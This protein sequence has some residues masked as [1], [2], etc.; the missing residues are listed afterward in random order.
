[1]YQFDKIQQ[2]LMPV[3]EIYQN[4]LSIITKGKANKCTTQVASVSVLS[5]SLAFKIIF[6]IL[7]YNSQLLLF[8]DILQLRLVMSLQLIYENEL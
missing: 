3:K 4:I 6:I 5:D 8:R 1:M 7:L 2:K